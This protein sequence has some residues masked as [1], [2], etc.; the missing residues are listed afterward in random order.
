MWKIA[1]SRDGI[2]GK[3]YTI[4]ASD[5]WILQRSRGGE[6][7]EIYKIAFEINL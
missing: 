6:E 3:D 5:T 4:A 7:N 2:A 1:G